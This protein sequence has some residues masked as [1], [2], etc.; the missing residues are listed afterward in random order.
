MWQLISAP[1]ESPS[2]ESMTEKT[3]VD[4][5]NAVSLQRTL[6]ALKLTEEGESVQALL[7]H[8][9]PQCL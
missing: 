1:C 3:A 7:P 9:P 2:S 4:S 6:T 5:G 8:T